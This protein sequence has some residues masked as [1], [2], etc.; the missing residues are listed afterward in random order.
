MSW[1]QINYFRKSE[2]LCPCCG[3]SDMYMPF[4]K[5]LDKARRYANVPFRVTSGFRCVNHNSNCGGSKS[6][7]HLSGKGVDLYCPSSSWRASAVGALLGFSGITIGIYS[8]KEHIHV[9]LDR[10]NSNH[11]YVK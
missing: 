7:F 10:N 6:S 9:H 3:K 2:F 4:V 1:N 5:I 11:C 8:V